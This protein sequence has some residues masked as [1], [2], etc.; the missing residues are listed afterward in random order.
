MGGGTVLEEIDALPGAEGEMAGEERDGKMDAGEGGADVGG[1]V[2][3]AFEGVDVVAGGFG[4]QA[5]EVADEVGLDVGVGVFLD[6]EGGGGV[7]AEEGEEASG[8]ALLADPGDDLAGEFVEALAAGGDG[9]VA[10]GLIHT[11]P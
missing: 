7:A 2:V 9:E 5:F 11:I 6:D 1:H 8:E 4:G 10:D 3:G